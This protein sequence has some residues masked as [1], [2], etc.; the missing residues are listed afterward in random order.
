MTTLVVC[1]AVIAA[2]VTYHARAQASL[3]ASQHNPTALTDFGSFEATVYSGPDKGV[4]LRGR[5]KLR[6]SKTGVL[7]GQLVPKRG[8]AIPLSGQLTGYAI[9]LVFYL[10]HGL[11]IFGVGTIGKDPGA[12]TLVLGGPLVGPNKGDGGDWAAI[13][14]L[15]SMQN[16]IIL[17]NHAAQP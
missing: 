14:D 3:P 1:T 15:S 17:T 2:G 11:H 12:K 6:A 13:G 10:G 5:L 16:A 7:G 8:A 9:N 4:A